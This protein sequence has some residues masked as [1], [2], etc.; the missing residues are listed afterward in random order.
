MLQDIGLS[1][2]E[3]K[4]YLSLLRKGKSSIGFIVQDS[5][6]PRSKIYEVLNRLIEKGLVSFALE[7]KIKVFFAVPPKRLN[8]FIEDEI[9]KKQSKLKE[10]IEKLEEIKPKSSGYSVEILVG[11]RGLKAFFN[12]LLDIK[13]G[14]TIYQIGY[15]KLPEIT[16]EEFWEK[17]HEKRVEKGIY[18]KALHYHEAWEKTKHKPRE[19]MEKR[20]LPK[21]FESPLVIV[22]AGDIVG[23]IIITSQ[24][25]IVFLIKSKEVTENYTKYFDL[26]WKDSK[27]RIKENF[28]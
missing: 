3:S 27:E 13:K 1:E 4:A 10:I 18:A 25:Q 2:R 12:M 16:S 17:F 24:E 21:G 19:K 6:I 28:L 23:N 14:E 8:E 20:P 11:K 22:F 26:L 7:G 5:G 9:E 15:Y